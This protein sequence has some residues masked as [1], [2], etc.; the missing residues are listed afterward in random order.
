[1][2]YPRIL[3][4]RVQAF[5]PK[6]GQELWSFATKQRVDSSPVIVGNRVFA[7]AAD[8]RLYGLNLKDGKQV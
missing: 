7:G 5:D 6:T 8:G 4:T 3:Q 2:E 1:M